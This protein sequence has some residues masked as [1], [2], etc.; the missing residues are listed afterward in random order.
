MSSELRGTPRGTCFKNG[1]AK[2]SVSFANGQPLG[3]TRGANNTVL[4]NAGRAGRISRSISTAP[5]MLWPTAWIGAGSASRAAASTA[6]SASTYQSKD[7]MVARAPLDN[8]CP[9]WS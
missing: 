9:G 8:P 3:R 1:R 5:P 7:S 2:V 6:S 4:L